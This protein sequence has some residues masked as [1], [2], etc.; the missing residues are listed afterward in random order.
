MYQITETGTTF[1]ICHF[2]WLAD[3]PAAP[4]TQ[5]TV[6]YDREGYL[7]RFVS[8]ETNLR[9]AETRHNTMVCCDSCMEVFLQY[10]PD[11]DPRYIN[12]EINPNRAVYSAVSHDRAHSVCIDPAE[13][14]TLDVTARCYPDRW[15]IDCRVP[16]AYIQKQI[17]TYRHEKGAHLRGNFYKCGDLTD[18]PH[19]GCFNNITWSQPDFHRPEFFADFELA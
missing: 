18:H 12:I 9:A 11:T 5:V 2:P 17:P 13:I 16:V 8:Y 15:E 14:D 1:A 3:Y 4:K 7:F 10:A 6:S 19:F